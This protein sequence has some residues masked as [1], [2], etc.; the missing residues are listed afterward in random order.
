VR[1]PRAFLASVTVALV[2]AAPAHAQ[3]TGPGFF[4]FSQPSGSW[5]LRGGFAM[6]SA[7]SD[8]FTFT[9]NNLTINR[10]DFG[11][12]DAGGDL[13]FAIQPRLDVVFDVSY[14]GMSKLSEFRDFV[15][16]NN[17]PIQQTTSFQ[18]TPITVN[19]RYYLMDRGRQVG[20]YAW[21]PSK[22]VPYVGAGAGMMYYDFEQKGDFIDDSTNAV[23]TDAFRSRGWA[24]TAQVIGG[25]EWVLG[26]NWALRTE[27][28]YLFG[29]AKPGSDFQGFHNIDLSGLTTSA[30]FF[31]RF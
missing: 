7:R 11:A 1:I 9:T 2:L 25:A 10:K 14:S 15:D 4:F 26:T 16:N 6:P 18:R 17:Q 28:R 13:A 21:V 8:L 31:L 24:P 23:F 22:V 3:D 29:S 12:F 5:S 27:A 20:H 19:L 30:G